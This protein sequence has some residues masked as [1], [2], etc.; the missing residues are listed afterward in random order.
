MENGT[1]TFG[2]DNCGPKHFLR[3]AMR[4]P[5]LMSFS[6]GNGNGKNGNTRKTPPNRKGTGK[7]PSYTKIELKFMREYPRKE[8]VS[9]LLQLQKEILK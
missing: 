5:P 6:N 7:K 2:D 4:T 9:D 8:T 3:Y 1:D